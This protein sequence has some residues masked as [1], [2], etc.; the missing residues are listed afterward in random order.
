MLFVHV[1]HLRSIEQTRREVQ[2]L[3]LLALRAFGDRESLRAH[4]EGMA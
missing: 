1:L 4:E 3:Q 2:Y